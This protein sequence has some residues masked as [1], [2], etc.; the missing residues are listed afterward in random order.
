MLIGSWRLVTGKRVSKG[1]AVLAKL[2]CILSGPVEPQNTSCN[3]LSTHALM[4]DD[5]VQEESDH[6]LIEL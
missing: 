2:G 1:E 4:V 5:Y 3:I 6:T